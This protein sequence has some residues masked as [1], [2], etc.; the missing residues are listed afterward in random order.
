MPLRAGVRA[1]SG[2]PRA[3]AFYLVLFLTLAFA[4]V[5]CAT[6]VD[7]QRLAVLHF[8]DFHGQLESYS[9]PDTGANVGGIARLAVAV[10]KVRA[11]DP[12]RQVL[13]LFAGDLL[14][15][16]LTSSLFLGVPDVVFLDELGVDAA[17]VG[18]HEF[19]Y[20]QD[21]FRHLAA[22][23]HFPFLTANVQTVSEP[24]PVKPYLLISKPGGPKVAILGLTTRELTTT[25]HPR[26]AVG[27]RVEDPL[28]VARRLTPSLREKGDMLIV[29]SHMGIADD[30]ELARE[31]PDIDLIVGG[32]N[33]NLYAQPVMVGNVAIVQAGERGRWLGRMDLAC[34]HGRMVRTGYQMLSMDAAVPQDPEVAAE[35]ARVVAEA[36]K[37]LTHEVGRTKVALS[38]R[39]ED[40]RRRESAFGNWV[41]DLAREI[42]HAD[43]ALING[44]NF[45]AGIP[46]GPVTLKQ[47]Y[48][49][50]PFRDELVV[51]HLTGAQLIEALQRSAS[52][53]PEDNPGGFL[54][55]SGLR[56]SIA[57]GSLESAT[58]ANKP[59][60]PT[61]RYLVVVPDFLAEGGDGYAM[62]EDMQ[63]KVMTGQLVSDMVIQA[64]RTGV[65]V[66][67]AV[68]GRIRR[69]HESTRRRRSDSP[70]PFMGEGRGEG[71]IRG[72]ATFHRRGWLASPN[73]RQQ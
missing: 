24:L 50:F 70:S 64:F 36:D 11:E 32:H 6:C 10:E 3:L 19:D 48:E 34:S 35:V 61:R 33:H 62:L 41:A 29:L 26:N 13:L 54:Q 47:I 66:T 43:A 67:A 22:L 18:N 73:D 57:N 12:G 25:T 69:W 52:L 7:G 45:R 68:D 44:G 16:T 72:E 49:A 1:W 46:A 21:A 2:T 38:A 51:G 8:N 4:G 23:A 14:Q 55:V 60:D 30:R 71:A 37:G 58:L 53:S 39:R 17:V 31:I 28:M 42:T 63:D 20:G 27:I 56:Y 59:I 15:G 9:D 5:A 40:I 65:P